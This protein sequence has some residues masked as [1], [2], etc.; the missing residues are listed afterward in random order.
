M[1][2]AAGTQNVTP[3]STSE[4]GTTGKAG[5]VGLDLSYLVTTNYGIGAFIRYA[6][7]ELNLP[8]AP[9]LKVGGLQ[10][11]GGLRLRF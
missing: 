5:N 10:M 6:G 3:T 2:V 11:G 4:S 7:G 1:A 9:N 8:T